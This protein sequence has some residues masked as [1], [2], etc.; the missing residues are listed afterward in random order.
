MNLLYD[1]DEDPNDTARRFK[2][3]GN[4]CIIQATKGLEELV[5]KEGKDEQGNRTTVISNNPLK[6]AYEFY[7][8]GIE[9]KPTDNTLLAILYCNRAYAS[10][11]KGKCV[12]VSPTTSLSSLPKSCFKE[13][14]IPL[15]PF[16][17]LL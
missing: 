9:V 2:D 5:K 7:T 12:R 11:L 10:L 8:Q 17:F 16:F 15:F 4:E 6:D 1:P 14:Y 13:T 3:R